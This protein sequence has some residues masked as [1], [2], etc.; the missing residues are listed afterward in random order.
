MSSPWILEGLDRNPGHCKLFCLPF[1]GGGASL[2]A[3]WNMLAPVAEA[4]PV[5]LPGRE[6]RLRETPF[7]DWTKLLSAMVNTLGR[8]MYGAWAVFGHSFGGLL[9]YEFARAAIRDGYQQ[10]EAVFVSACRPPDVT[11]RFSR[12]LYKLSDDELVAELENLGASP[13]PI[14]ADAE[15]R[16]IVLPSVRADI[17]LCETYEHVSD[18]VLEAPIVA[19]SGDEDPHADASEMKRWREFTPGAFFQQTVPG[20]HFFLKSQA[21]LLAAH[22]KERL[23]SLTEGR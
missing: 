1:A 17:Q 11:T 7:T 14:L 8:E 5:Q 16:R 10:P 18:D 19:F 12:T 20:G 13:N 21:P 15:T 4:L 2:F 22:V 3:G 23:Q 9:A 6:N